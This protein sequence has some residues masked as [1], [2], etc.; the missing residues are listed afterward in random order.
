M[1]DVTN[2]SDQAKTLK[3]GSQS[4]RLS[5]FGLSFCF[6]ITSF[7]ECILMLLL[8]STSIGKNNFHR[9]WGYGRFVI[10]L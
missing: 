4:K 9:S 5:S 10:V 3:N 2:V 1:F 8:C 6:A 7:A